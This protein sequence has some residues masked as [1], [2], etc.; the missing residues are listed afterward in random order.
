MRRDGSRYA[1]R[2]AGACWGGLAGGGP[3]L[4]RA[5]E[6][7]VLEAAGAAGL[8]PRLVCF[9]L[10][11]G[12]L[13]AQWAEGYSWTPAEVGTPE[14]IRA[15]AMLL[16]RV[17]AM[18]IPAPARFMSP[19]SWI[20]HY[21]SALP[22]PSRSSALSTSAAFRLQ[23][24]ASIPRVRGVICHSDLH[25]QNVIQ[26]PSGLILLDWEYAHVSD[27]FWDLAGWSANNDLDSETQRKLVAEYLG[28]PPTFEQWQRFKTLSWLYDYVC[29]SWSE[30]YLSLPGGTDTGVAQR[31]TELDARLHIPA[32]YAAT[33]S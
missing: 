27:P 15:V 14:R 9:D 22:D 26:T 8:A 16:R 24:L 10:Q 7:K 32:H 4:D 5:W 3:A 21:R 19:A 20:E 12:L 31:A 28:S 17:H 25:S 33:H 6:V 29:L 30:I 2:L 11:R 18:V 1:V 23:Q 13:V